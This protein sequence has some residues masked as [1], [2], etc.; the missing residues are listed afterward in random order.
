MDWNV[1]RVLAE[2]DTL[3]LREK[4]IIVFMADHGYQLGE[5]GKWSKAGSLFEMGTRVPLIMV[6]PDGKG[7]GRVCPRMVE[8]L[9]VYP[10]LVELCDLPV[11]AG[12]EGQS[13]SP[14]LKKPDGPMDR[15]AFSVW[16]EDGKTL[17][18]VAVRVDR[19]RYAEFADGGVMLID[20]DN[21]PQELKNVADDP[22]NK[23]A[24]E[25]LSKLVKDYQRD[26]TS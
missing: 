13:L 20:M 23:A 12:L 9:D 16:S 22:A 8:S 10:T 3:G 2:L 17:H 5:K 18:G 14:L 1:G 25:R 24:T 11:P 26:F 4:T 15:P 7:N 6:V 19:W 21:D